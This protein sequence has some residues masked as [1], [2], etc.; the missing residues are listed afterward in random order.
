[1]SREKLGYLQ[2]LCA[3]VNGNGLDG[4]AKVGRTSPSMKELWGGL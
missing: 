4:G 1:M 2:Q 3:Y